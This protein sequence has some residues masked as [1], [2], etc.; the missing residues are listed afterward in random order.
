MVSHL[1]NFLFRRH[2]VSYQLYR[3]EKLIAKK[4]YAEAVTASYLALEKFPQHPELEALNFEAFKGF[5]SY[6]YNQEF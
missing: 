1:I 6:L 4:K 2:T 5:S 3:I